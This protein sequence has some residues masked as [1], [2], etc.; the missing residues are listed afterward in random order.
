MPFI[1]LFNSCHLLDEQPLLNWTLMCLA[2]R[3]NR[4]PRQIVAGSDPLHPSLLSRLASHLT[5][6]GSGSMLRA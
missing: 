5:L 3:R 2:A 1:C 6:L 4:L